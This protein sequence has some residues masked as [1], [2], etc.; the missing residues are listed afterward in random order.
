MI[1]I[2]EGL[3][4]SGFARGEISD[5]PVGFAQHILPSRNSVVG[6]LQYLGGLVKGCPC[7]AGIGTRTWNVD[8]ADA[9]VRIGNRI[10]EIDQGIANGLPCQKVCFFESWQYQITRG[11]DSVPVEILATVHVADEGVFKV[12]FVGKFQAECFTVN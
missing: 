4:P 6:G 9:W 12:G 8:V 5:A 1:A 3:Q 11:E 2:G 10:G 7:V